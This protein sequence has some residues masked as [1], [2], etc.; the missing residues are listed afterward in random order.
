MELEQPWIAGEAQLLN[1]L[2]RPTFLCGDVHKD[3]V[4]RVVRQ[5]GSSVRT[6]QVP[7]LRRAGI[8]AQLG[9]RRLQRGEIDDTVTLQPIYLRR[10]AVT[11]STRHDALAVKPAEER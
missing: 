4:N 9:A 3:I 11:R 5:G 7:T 6:P 2:D 1:K 10:P 8:L